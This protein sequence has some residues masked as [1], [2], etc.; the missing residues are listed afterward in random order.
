MRCAFL[1]RILHSIHIYLLHPLV[2][3]WRIM[4]WSSGPARRLAL[5]C[6]WMDISF[7]HIYMAGLLLCVCV[8]VGCAGPIWVCR[9]VDA[10]VPLHFWPGSR[11]LLASAHSLSHT[12]KPFFGWVEWASGGSCGV[13]ITTESWWSSPSWMPAAWVHVYIG[14]CENEREQVPNCL[15]SL[16]SFTSIWFSVRRRRLPILGIRCYSTKSFY[17]HCHFYHILLLHSTLDARLHGLAMLKD[18]NARILWNES[19][20]YIRVE[21]VFIVLSRIFAFA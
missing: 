21:C 2:I 16:P 14:W 17:W 12:Y 5:A 20:L 13:Y 8:C 15:F 9:C 7:Q 3:F 1:S 6:V 18:Q 10:C 19:G 4:L 11:G